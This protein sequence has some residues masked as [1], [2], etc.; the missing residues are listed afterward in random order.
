M[1]SIC[2]P[3]WNRLDSLQRMVRNY[4]QSYSGLDLQF[5]ICDDGST[6]PP[7]AAYCPGCTFSL[8]DNWCDSCRIRVVITH[9]PFKKHPLNPC[10]PINRAVAASRGEIIVLTNPEM[11]H[12][13]WPLLG[14][15]GALRG[16]NDYVTACCYEE[17]RRLQLAGPGVDYS[18]GGR[19]PVPPWAHF[20][21]LAAFPRSL[22]DK[23]DGFDE[24]YRN[25]TACDDNDWLWRVYRA[26]AVFKNVPDVVY[27][28]PSGLHWRMPHG[29]R[30]FNEKWPPEYRAQLIAA[31]E[32]Q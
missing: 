6:N 31:R 28:H 30:L 2:V 29:R 11:E 9:L 24:D 27:H 16:D 5:S 14:V 17:K 22:W 10:V 15:L 26:G 21:F 12:R 32:D 19:L 7:L 8:L 3:H 20:H 13:D 1:I 25:V 18:S 23:A 4:V